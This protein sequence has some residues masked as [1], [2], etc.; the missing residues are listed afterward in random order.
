MWSRNVFVTQYHIRESLQSVT[1]P[2]SQFFGWGLGKSYC[3]VCL[4]MASYAKSI[5]LHPMTMLI[6]RSWIVHLTPIHC[7][8]FH[9]CS[10]LATQASTLCV[11]SELLIKVYALIACSHRK[12]CAYIMNLRNTLYTGKTKWPPT[13]TWCFALFSFHLGGGYTWKQ[14]NKKSS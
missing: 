4:N 9:F 8:L 5:T 7:S 12:V 14:K 10:N 3:W 2:L 13:Y 6:V 1:R 11:V